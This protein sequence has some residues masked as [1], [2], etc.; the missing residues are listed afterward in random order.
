[1]VLTKYN[2]AAYNRGIIFVTAI[3]TINSIP[4]IYVVFNVVILGHKILEIVS[5][6]FFVHCI[7]SFTVLVIFLLIII[8]YGSEANRIDI[9]VERKL[10]KMQNEIN[11]IYVLAT[12]NRIWEDSEGEIHIMNEIDGGKY[13][14]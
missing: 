3:F 13:K 8:I 1:M 11:T 7:Y 2:E 9:L 5:A 10:V 14:S 12:R 4:F 6:Y